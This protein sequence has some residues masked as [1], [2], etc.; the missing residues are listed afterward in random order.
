M[1][2]DISSKELFLRYT[3]KNPVDFAALINRKEQEIISISPECF[4]L[5]KNNKVLSFPVKGTIKRGLTQLEDKKLRQQLTTSEKDRAELAMIV[6]LIRNDIGKIAKPNSV[7]V[8]QHASLETFQTLYHLYS[9]IEG[10]IDLNKK[11]ELFLSMFPGGS[12][13]GAPKIRAMEII[14]ELEE[15]KREI[16]TGSIG[17]IGFSKDIN[18]NIAIRTIQKQ[19]NKMVYFTGGGITIASNEDDEFDE[20][21]LKSKTFF[22]IFEKVTFE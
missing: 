22:N 17:L 5:L 21:I 18:L 8:K 14:S 6:D 19:K 2:T 16:Y 9:V 3:K 20:T 10:E 15:Y 7:M 1:E 12:I 4:F 11:T 13:T